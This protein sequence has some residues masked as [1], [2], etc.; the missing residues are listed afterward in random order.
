MA[1]VANYFALKICL[2][3]LGE[4]LLSTPFAYIVLR[5]PRF[6]HGGLKRAFHDCWGHSVNAAL[7]LVQPKK[8]VKHFDM[9]EK[10]LKFM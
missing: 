4:L 1:A 3:N 6:V 7:V 2:G 8:T 10:L 9:T 5:S